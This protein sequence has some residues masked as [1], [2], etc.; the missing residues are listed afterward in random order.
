M[1][2][3][4]YYEIVQ[5]KQP[6]YKGCSV[7]DE[8]H[9]FQN[10]AKWFDENYYQCG[11]EKTHLDKDILFKKNK[12][13]SPDTCIFVPQKIN[14][15]FLKNGKNRGIYPIGVYFEKSRNKY[16]AHLCATGKTIGRYNAPEEAF[17]AYKQTKENYIKKV[18]DEYKSKYPQFPQKLYE[19]MYRYEVEI[20][21]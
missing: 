12:I 2:E 20:D 18:A 19:A 13:Y 4:C 14:L 7:C 5:S 10:F 21:D 11:N 17:Q 3:R 16:N 8:W 15:L 1:L 9:N 6:T